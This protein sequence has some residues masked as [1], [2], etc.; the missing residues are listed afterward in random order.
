MDRYDDRR[1]QRTL[2]AEEFE[3]LWERIQFRLAKV[4]WRAFAFIIGSGGV[5]AFL[6]DSLKQALKK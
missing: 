4:A 2:T 6:W 3:E 5:M 1:R